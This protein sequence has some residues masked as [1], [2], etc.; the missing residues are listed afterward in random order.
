M[1]ELFYRTANGIPA[2]DVATPPVLAQ[3]GALIRRMPKENGVPILG[4]LMPPYPKP[5]GDADEFCADFDGFGLAF[6][7][8]RLNGKAYLTAMKQR[9]H[10]PEPRA[11]QVSH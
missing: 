5:A 1:D 4:T 11:A 8:G 10:C 2:D 9:A 3:A 7:M 6:S